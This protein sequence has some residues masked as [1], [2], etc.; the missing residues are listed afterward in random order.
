MNKVYFLVT[1]FFAAT[2]L[3]G[4]TISPKR[5]LAGDLADNNDCMAVDNYLTWYYNWANTPAAAVINTE[6]NYIEYAPMLWNGSWNATAL[7]NY[8][9]AHP[10]V[11]YLLAFNEPNFN[12]Q[13]NMTPAQAAAIWPQVE[14]IAN[15]HNL[16]IVSPALGY[17]SGTCIAGYNNMDGTK[18]L[19]DFFAACPGCQVDHIAIHI[20]DTWLYGFEGVLN[21][22]RKYNKPI[23]VT[24]FDR[25]GATTATQ[26]AQL[27]VDVIDFMEKDPAV[28]R[29]AWFLARSSPGTT[30]TDI[31]TQTTGNFTNLGLIYT[32]M[33]SYDNAFYHKVNNIIE[34]EHYID[35]SVTYC[36]WNGSACAWPY[37]VLLEATSDVSGTLDAYNFLSATDDTIFYNVDIPATQSYTIDFR[38]NTSAASTISVHTYP[39]NVLLGT[40]ASL[41]SAG[42]WSTKTLNSVNLAAGKQKIYLTASNGSAMK[43][44]WLRINC[45]SSCGYLPVEFT[46]F[47]ALKNPDASVKLRWQTASEKDNQEF[48]I[49]R[50]MDGI[51]FEAIGRV[52]GNN[53]TGQPHDYYFDD[54]YAPAAEVYYRLKQVDVDGS[55]TYSTVRSVNLR[56]NSSIIIYPNPVEDQLNI[57]F[58]EAVDID[59]ISIIDLLGRTVFESGSEAYHSDV[60]SVSLNLHNIA[61]GSYF[62]RI[63]KRG[64]APLIRKIRVSGD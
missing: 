56:E 63:K 1:F 62:L 32:Y 15:A 10:E 37:S 6:Q 22:Y 14:A 57:Q 11:K 55:F 59:D 47:Q 24:E 27:M 40:T 39:G 8:L 23:W 2:S 58:G 29:Y 50:S 42:A 41:N 48:I 45:A 51:Q 36:G 4:Q 20:Y 26:H 46:D 31:L 44:N 5:G 60:F 3:A 34:A 12:V 25:S 53:T 28:F 17:C 13:A 9:T 21:P 49:E 30:S 52:P 18:W 35:K 16:K 38:V 7:N 43:L 64:E 54:L 19:D 33:S 61:G